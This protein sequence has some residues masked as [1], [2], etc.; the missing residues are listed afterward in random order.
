MNLDGQILPYIWEVL[1]YYFF[2]YAFCPLLPL[3]PFLDSRGSQT[4][5]LDGILQFMQAFFTLLHY[6]SLLFS[7]PITQKSCFLFTDSF[8]CLI[9]SFGLSPPV[10]KVVV[11]QQRLQGW[12]KKKKDTTSS[13]NP[14]PLLCMVTPCIL[15]S[16]VIIFPLK[17]HVLLPLCFCGRCV[18]AS[19]NANL[20][21][22]SHSFV[23]FCILRNFTLAVN[24]TPELPL[25]GYS[26]QYPRI[27]CFHNTC[28]Y[29]LSQ[30]P[31]LPPL[32]CGRK[33][34]TPLLLRAVSTDYFHLLSS[35]PYPST[36]V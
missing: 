3:F 34:P 33:L 6:F 18:L 9:H 25:L 2:K 7:D 28:T 13:F 22:C 12:G 11:L 35:C 21:S 32:Y 27:S 30:V 29:T 16:P 24:C 1:S 15:P 5:S 8:F 26:H 19:L 4:A 10:G 23:S 36:P 14:L 17:S 31:F 20:S